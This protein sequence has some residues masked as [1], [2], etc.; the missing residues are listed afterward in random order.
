V[1]SSLDPSWSHRGI[2]LCYPSCFGPTLRMGWCAS[3]ITYS[4]TLIIS[5]HPFHHK[6]WYKQCVTY[7]I[8]SHFEDLCIK[9][10]YK[11]IRW[12][13]HK[14]SMFLNVKSNSKLWITTRAHHNVSLT[15][16]KDL[17]LETKKLLMSH[18]FSDVISPTPILMSLSWI[19]SIPNAK[20]SSHT[21]HL[22]FQLLLLQLLDI[23]LAPCP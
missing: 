18:C 17:S 22:Y 7:L 14:T 11:K 10:Y 20:A 4:L 9:W 23:H 6:V 5:H 21:A 3:W 15:S 16:G 19:F 13:K 2:Y 1:K 12:N 8:M